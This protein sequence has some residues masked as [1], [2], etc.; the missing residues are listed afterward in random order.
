MRHSKSF[1]VLLTASMLLLPFAQAE[2]T[3]EDATVEAPQ[4]K[5]AYI[6]GQLRAAK[7]AWEKTVAERAVAAK[8][9]AEKAA[10][11]KA[12]ADRGLPSTS[13]VPAEIK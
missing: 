4:S 10:A 6:D 13:R 1:L 2:E 8:V 5:A 7:A 3:L 12:A 9:A 11:E